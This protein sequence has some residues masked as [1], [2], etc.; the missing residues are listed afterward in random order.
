MPAPMPAQTM[1]RSSCR[2][3]DQPRDPEDYT[4]AVGI[5]SAPPQGA[6]SSSAGAWLGPIAPGKAP[7]P[8][9]PPVPREVE[10][11]LPLSV[12]SGGGCFHRVGSA[13]LVHCTH[14]S[15]YEQCS[16]CK[17]ETTIEWVSDQPH[18]WFWASRY[19]TSNCGLRHSGGVR[20]T[21]CKHCMPG[22]RHRR[23]NR[24]E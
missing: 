8:R 10:V 23:G 14:V 5:G 18:L 1:W 11:G 17:G 19:H 21:P 22:L 9:P 24:G 16:R 2:L 13:Q 12:T 20:Y 15:S 6:S 3:P 7:A 4:E